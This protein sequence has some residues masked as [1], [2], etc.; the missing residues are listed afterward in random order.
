MTDI[1]YHFYKLSPQERLE[2]VRQFVGLAESDVGVL[3]TPGGLSLEK[4][5]CMIENVIGTIEV[6]LGA[7]V[8]FSVNGKDHVVPM[9]TEEASVVAAVCKMGKVARIKGG[10]VA[11]S[12]EPIMI[13]QI[14]IVGVQDPFGAKMRVLAQKK[15]ILEIANRQNPPL[16][17]A[18][19]GAIDV[20][21]RVVDTRSGPMV[22]CHLLVNCRDAMGA[23]AVNSMAEALKKDLEEISG[24]VV[25]LRILSNFSI[26]RMAR[27][28]AVFDS[29]ELGGPATVNAMVQAYHFADADIYRATTH[30][31]GIMNGITAV[32]MATGQDTR[33]IEAG[34]HAYA[35]SSGVYRSL[36]TWEKNAGGDLVGAL[37][38]PIAVGTIGGATKV[39]PAAQAN[40][41]ILGVQSASELAEIMV[42]VGLAQNAAALRALV[43]E[44]IQQGHMALHA[45]NM[46]I[47]A[48]APLEL[49]DAV[50]SRMMNNGPIRLDSA[51]NVVRE[52]TG[53]I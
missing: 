4:A 36:T 20:E 37:E 38:L 24:G 32:A 31:K 35:S 13:G 42:S 47:M 52:L 53:N 40:L 46:A 45:R 50:V 34:A 16:I 22:I 44:G 11:H 3:Q 1:F 6:P 2:R 28:S 39:H 10:F 51:Q 27:A 14:Q 12:T 17:A 26:H 19:G 18:G 5:N 43:N 48:G 25:S 23:N 30:N 15:R 29:A 33:A 41:K 21:V 9:A 49:V 8:R 7:A